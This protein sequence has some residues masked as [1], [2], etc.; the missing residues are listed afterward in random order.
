MFERRHEPLLPFRAFVLRVARSLAL[1]FAII[2]FALGMGVLGYHYLAEF[3][4]VDSLL[5]ASMILSGMGPVGDFKNDT[6]KVFASFYALF[7]GLA[8]ITI[9]GIIVAP[10]AHRLLHWFHIEEDKEGKRQSAKA[11]RQR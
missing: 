6:G 5:N 1:A 3:A 10:V 7:S 11:K 8:F 9:A 4:W 2:A